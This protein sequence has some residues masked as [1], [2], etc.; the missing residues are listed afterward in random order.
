MLVVHGKIITPFQLTVE[1][2][3]DNSLFS[4]SE[5]NQLHQFL[6]GFEDQGKA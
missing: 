2:Y 1:T 5:Q 3:L 6:D 4:E